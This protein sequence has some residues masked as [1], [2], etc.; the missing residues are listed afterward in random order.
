MEWEEL[1]NENQ[2]TK[3]KVH[4]KMSSRI[5]VLRIFPGITSEAVSGLNHLFTTSCCHVFNLSATMNFK[6]RQVNKCKTWSH[7]WGHTLGFHPQTNKLEPA[8]AA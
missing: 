4:T 7:V 5:G 3:F 2:A 6:F 1:F 8:C